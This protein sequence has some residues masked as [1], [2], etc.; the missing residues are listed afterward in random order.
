M[1]KNVMKILV[2]ALSLLMAIGIA[3][4]STFAWFSL[5][6]KVAVTG[7]H[8]T[9]KV[10]NSILI[11]PSTTN[12]TT[13]EADANFKTN[14]VATSNT[15]LEPVSSVDGVNFFYTATTNVDAVGNAVNDTY[16]AYV[17]GDDF[18]TNY[19]VNTTPSTPD[20]YGYVDYAF[21]LKVS[22]TDPSATYY[23]NFTQLALLYRGAETT[24]KAFRVAIFVNDMGA[25]GSTAA[26]APTTD[27]LKVL[28]TPAEAAY[29]TAN[30]A[31]SDSD[32]VSSI[33]TAI[34]AA[35]CGSTIS[36]GTGK[37]NIGTV[38]AHSVRFFKVVVRL[39]LEGEDSTCT[40]DTFA[41]LTNDWALNMAIE[42]QASAGTIAVINK[43]NDTNSAVLTSAGLDDPEVK[44][45]ID[46]H[47][48]Y[49]LDT[50]LNSTDL[51]I[52]SNTL[53]NTSRVYTIAEGKYLTDVT[54][55]C[56]LPAPTP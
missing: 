4:G 28:L 47:T 2:A 15:L 34:T 24:E 5:N 18:D 41:T 30:S 22:N 36:S 51:Y 31:V 8:V 14:Y 37:A 43:T 9:T 19:N 44:V 21:Q 23:V 49:K 55:Q 52:D 38:A 33:S 27:S 45:E 46:G 6:S 35:K 10:S 1:K 13:K 40:T 20:A 7:M 48:Y 3:T 17:A 42:L 32:T 12:G 50:Q 26:T 53:S 39:W 54:T 56:T 25:D 29:F 11:A 16:I